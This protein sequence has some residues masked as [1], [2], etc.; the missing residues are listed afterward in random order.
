MVIEINVVVFTKAKIIFRII[1]LRKIFHYTPAT[2]QLPI[3]LLIFMWVVGGIS[4]PNP[5]YSSKVDRQ[6]TEKNF[7]IF[8]PSRTVSVACLKVGN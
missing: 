2:C 5:V 4:F 3:N 7:L 1:D 6:E 8:F